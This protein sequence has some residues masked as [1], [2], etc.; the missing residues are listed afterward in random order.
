MADWKRDAFGTYIFEELNGI[1]RFLETA[2]KLGLPTPLDFHHFEAEAEVYRSLWDRKRYPGEPELGSFPKPHL[3]PAFAMAQ[4]YGVPTRFLDWTESPL[5]AAFF[6]AHG[7]WRAMVREARIA[8]RSRRPIP[9]HFSIVPISVSSLED[10]GLKLVNAPRAGNDFMRAQQGLFTLM[11]NANTF[12]WN[13]E[14][15]PAVNDVSKV[16]PIILPRSEAVELLRILYQLDITLH[17]LMPTLENAANA[18]LWKKELFSHHAVTLHSQFEPDSIK[19]RFAAQ[20]PAP[21]PAQEVP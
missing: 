12:W 3:Y 18:V 4:H 8:R 5:I 6:A 11:P 17:D 9:S 2:D 16:Y 14:R 15:W 21:E 13:H 1:S 10:H 20:S 19:P 7:V